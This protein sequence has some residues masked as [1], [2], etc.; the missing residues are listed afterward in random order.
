VD[1]DQ[2]P[3]GLNIFLEIDI[4]GMEAGNP[5]KFNFCIAKDQGPK[6]CPIERYLFE[7]ESRGASVCSLIKRE[8][9]AW[10]KLKKYL[11]LPPFDTARSKDGI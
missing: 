2:T 8:S 11:G 5:E 1:E 3:C 10:S 6:R 4:C 9:T 7:T